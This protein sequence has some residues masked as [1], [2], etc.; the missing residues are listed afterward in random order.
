MSTRILVADDHEVVRAGVVAV[1]RRAPKLQVVGEASDGAEAVEEARKLRPDVVVIDLT[2]PGLEGTEAI[3]RLRRL[4]PPPAVVVLS[5]HA[6]P[7]RAAWAI[8]AGAAAY[9]LKGGDASEIVDAVTKAANRGTHVT[10]S[11]AAEVA[12]LL[13]A[14]SDDPLETLTGR[15]R[16]VLQLVAEGHTN[17]SIAERLSISA[18]TV[19]HHRTN[20]M[21]KLDLHDV[22]SVV[23]FALRRGLVSS[24]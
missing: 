9:V 21:Q 23:R 5:M 17:A 2:M 18:K 8:R 22:A 15:E 6:A 19:D 16:E 7:E 24:E 1:L 10:P 12:A 14:S 11:L 3:R 20:L 13:A 4:D